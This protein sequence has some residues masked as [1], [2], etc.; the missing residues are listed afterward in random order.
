MK[1]IGPPHL[2]LLRSN[3]PL[4]SLRYV[5]QHFPSSH[6]T[7]W[8]QAGWHHATSFN[9]SCAVCCR[10]PISKRAVGRPD[11]PGKLSTASKRADQPRRLKYPTLA[12]NTTE[13]RS[14]V[15]RTGCIFR[16]MLSIIC[17]TIK[18]LHRSIGVTKTLVLSTD[19][20]PHDDIDT[21][22]KSV[23]TPSSMK[24]RIV[25]DHDPNDRVYFRPPK[26]LDEMTPEERH[27]FA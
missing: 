5:D 16:A 7:G 21:N 14:A 20:W 6:L 8:H 19:T 18:I 26:P 1:L 3:S 17:G 9:S 12:S 2:G 25:S 4:P 23:V 11:R 13:V 15:C 10:I 22:L 24:G 27:E